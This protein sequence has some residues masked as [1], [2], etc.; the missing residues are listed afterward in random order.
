MHAFIHMLKHR[1]V[2]GEIFKELGGFYLTFSQSKLALTV[3]L[4]AQK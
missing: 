3:C 1:T 4:S 2:E